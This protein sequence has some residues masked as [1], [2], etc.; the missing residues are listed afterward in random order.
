MISQNGKNKLWITVV[1]VMLLLSSACTSNKPIDV[2]APAAPMSEQRIERYSSCP[3]SPEL[4]YGKGAELDG[5]IS[6]T[7]HRNECLQRKK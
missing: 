5:G 2:S 7:G 3:E 1:L 6:G 4:H